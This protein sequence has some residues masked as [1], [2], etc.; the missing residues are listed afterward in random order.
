[1]ERTIL[2][3]EDNEDN[4]VIYT[5]VLEH[6]GHRVVRAA[7]GA[8]GLR[9]ARELRPTLI[10]LD[11]SLPVLSGWDVAAAIRAESGT[12]GIPIVVCTA[13]DSP[14]DQAR[15][16]QLGCQGFLVKPCSPR[17]LIRAI[18]SFL[19]PADRQP[20]ENARPAPQMRGASLRRAAVAL[21]VLAAVA[22]AST[23]IYSRRRPRGWSS[24][25]RALPRQRFRR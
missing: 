10:L 8:E 19:Q 3:V 7:D 18:D 11:L 2:L 23:R 13:H 1:M 16:V 17:H 15:A 25:L 9:L 12:A 20:V 21:A 22:A 6:F 24:R 14:A 5:A 4:A